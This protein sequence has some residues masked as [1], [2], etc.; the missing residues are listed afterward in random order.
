MQ[1]HTTEEGCLSVKYEDRSRRRRYSSE[2]RKRRKRLNT[3]LLFLVNVILFCG[4]FLLGQASAAPSVPMLAISPALS[5][6]Q[7]R[8]SEAKVKNT[9]A[10]IAKD[11]EEMT[12]DKEPVEPT[13]NLI[14][15]NGDHPLPEDFQVPELTQL[16]NGH[17]FDS[18]A[19]EALQNMLEAARADGLHPLICSSFRTWEKQNS[20]F[21]R[22]VNRYLE[23]GYSLQE[24]E[25]MAAHWVA[26]PGTSEHQTGLAVDIVD[27]SYQL[28]DEQQ[29]QTPVQ[30]W[31]M[32]HCAEYG[33][34]L[35]YPKDKSD[36][37]GVGY[38]PWHY[39]YV[40]EEAAR[41][42]MEQGICLEEYQLNH[43]NATS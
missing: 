7:I 23:Q 38:E 2:Y 32:E 13:W 28:L 21:T 17:A 27:I 35:R 5:S 33:F 25:T 34:I 4:G 29:E 37:T 22:K 3:F 39:R 19:Y 11:F 12:E 10:E 30:R 16:A 26:R 18:R 8:Q 36:L 9:P 15:V 20:L 24:A 6:E 41:E 40:G 1:N 43:V 42:I 31:L 14:L